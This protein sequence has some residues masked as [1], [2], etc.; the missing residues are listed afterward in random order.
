MLIKSKIEELNLEN[1]RVFLRL[2][3]NVEI[4]NQEIKSDFK[5]NSIL[6]TLNLLIKKKAKIIIA[7]HIDRPKSFNKNFST[8]ILLNY[9]ENLGYKIEF[10]PDLNVA[11][12]KSKEN[13]KNILLLENLRFYKGERSQDIE[14]AK[15]L[16]ELADFYINDAFGVIHRKDTSVYLLPKLFSLSNKSIGLLIEK[17]IENLNIIKNKKGNNLAILSGAKVKDKLPLIKPL[18]NIFNNIIICPAI[19]FTFLKALKINT[20]IS[21]V[22][23]KLI[24]KSLNIL[25]LAKINNKNIIF[26]ID[27]QVSY[28]SELKYTDKFKDNYNGISIGPKSI[29]LFNG[30]INSADNIILNGEF[31]FLSIKNSL[32]SFDLILKAISKS[33][34]FKVIAGGDSV[35]RIYQINLESKIDFCS[36]GGGATLAYLAGKKLFGL[37]NI[38]DL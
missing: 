14:F 34:A 31:G 36:T 9:F 18:L 21:L 7:T 15:K 24:E 22:E 29:E 4:E 38:T 35:S 19:V 6:P 17:E 25:K 20:G 32:K 2:D 8:K 26:P 37:I 11:I 16:K 3:L 10:Q 5:L 23:D 1:K 27:Y 30:Y 12:Y 33:K 13:N 28:N